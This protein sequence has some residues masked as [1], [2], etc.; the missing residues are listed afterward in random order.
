[1]SAVKEFEY[2]KRTL[3]C[4]KDDLKTIAE[5]VAMLPI[6]ETNN[7]RKEAAEEMRSRCAGVIRMLAGK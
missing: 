3:K 6:R 5:F 7:A 4:S 2:I 1:M